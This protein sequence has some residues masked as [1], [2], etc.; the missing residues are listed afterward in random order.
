MCYLLR[1]LVGW[2]ITIPSLI[3][4][5]LTFM[6]E[7]IFTL[8]LFGASFHFLFDVAVFLTGQSLKKSMKAI[9]YFLQFFFIC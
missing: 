1:I 3:V 6:C 8:S 5:L 7:L 2:R 4:I 9:V